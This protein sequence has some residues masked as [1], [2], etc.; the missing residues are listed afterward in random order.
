MIL[1]GAAASL[2]TLVAAACGTGSDQAQNA[3]GGSAGT[4]G[5]PH[6]AGTLSVTH[7]QGTTAVPANPKKVFTFDFGV[8]DTM[9]SLGLEAQGVP[10]VTFPSSLKKYEDSSFIKIG[11]AK[12]P[13][14]EK[15]ANEAPDLIIITSRAASS[16]KELSKIAPTIDLTVDMKDQWA[17]F[18]ERAGVVAQIFGKEAELKTKLAEL[19]TEADSIKVKAASAGSA[20]FLLTSGGAVNAYGPGSRFGFIY[21]LLGLKSV[22]GVESKDAHGQAVS[23][24]FLK[25]KNPQMLFVLDRDEAIGQT[26]A[27]QSA[28]QLLDNDLVKSTDAAKNNKIT[29]VDGAS[30]YLVGFGLQ[31]LKAMFAEIKSAL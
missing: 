6:A 25:Q 8:L 1:G 29:Y 16:Y 2:V 10:A 5:S 22:S 20:L 12:E 28:K 31:N 4:S 3:N 23:Y 11:S 7:A 15:I 17:S 24:E 27:G 30:W 18:Q 21:S 9:E 14:F 19:K 26:K 13:D